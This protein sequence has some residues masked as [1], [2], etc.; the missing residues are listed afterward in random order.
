MLIE[1][2]ALMLQ[3][4]KINLNIQTNL[5]EEKYSMNLNHS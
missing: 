4:Y 2:K 5:V 1:L 3:E